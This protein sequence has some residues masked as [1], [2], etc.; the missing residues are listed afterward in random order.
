MKTLDFRPAS[1][2]AYTIHEATPERLTG[3]MWLGK[4]NPGPPVHIHPRLAE[5]LKML[6]GKLEIFAEGTWK[7]I[8]EGHEWE[9]PAGAAHTFRTPA[10]S[11]ARVWFSVEPAGGF[12]GFLEDTHALVQAGRLKRYESLSGLLYSSMI[13]RKYRGD[14]VASGRGMRMLMAAAAAVGRLLGKR[15]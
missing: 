12:L 15:V 13:V 3:E 2:E 1:D 11:E 4:G 5:R 10:D 8:E 7:V 6:E 9:V 14:F